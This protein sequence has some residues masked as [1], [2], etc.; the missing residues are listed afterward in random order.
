MYVHELPNM[1]VHTILHTT[2]LCFEYQN[3]RKP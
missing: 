3:V 2:A 1:Y